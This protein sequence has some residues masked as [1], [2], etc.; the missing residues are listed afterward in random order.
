[1]RIL[2]INCQRCG[3]T[4]GT[5]AVLLVACIRD[6]PVLVEAER[7]GDIDAGDADGSTYGD[8]ATDASNPRP[9]VPAAPCEIEL[10]DDQGVFVSESTGNDEN[11]GGRSGPFRTL[12]AAAAAGKPYIYVCEG[13]Y[14][15]SLLIDSSEIPL[16]ASSE[17]HIFGSYDCKTWKRPAA[18]NDPTTV[19]RP[20]DGNAALHVA[21]KSVAA[22]VRWIRLDTEGAPASE[23]QEDRAVEVVDASLKLAAVDVVA[24]GR[25][26]G[27]AGADGADG[28]PGGTTSGSSAG[29]GGGPCGNADNSG[30]AGGS[31]P[32]GSPQDG[33]PGNPANGGGALGKANTGRAGAGG[34]G[35]PGQPGA[36]GGGGGGYQTCTGLPSTG[37]GGG[38]GGGGA[39]GGKDGTKGGNSVAIW[40]R[41]AA[42][43]QAQSS[44]LFATGGRGGDGGKGGRGG[45]GGN[46]SSLCGGL[47]GRGGGG[48]GGNSGS[49]GNAYGIVAGPTA[50][51]VWNEE[52]LSTTTQDSLTGVALRPGS[53]GDPGAGGGNNS[54]SSDPTKPQ[55]EY[56]GQPGKAGTKGTTFTFSRQE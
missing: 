15:D 21:G 24:S 4:I 20:H 48:G 17:V 44:R 14:D 12:R 55:I 39:C 53:P 22:E 7:D 2:D 42:S 52:T 25:G 56:A 26:A 8:G 37:Y 10:C 13:T 19:V 38:G 27:T 34:G 28:Q 16:F 1:M 6:E 47:G 32:G 18:L 36:G 50:K 29:N 40:L 33:Q 45:A 51:V 31:A 43:F 41:G 3:I 9:P 23:G 30:G 5:A 54:P 11:L 35:A 49:G 46:N